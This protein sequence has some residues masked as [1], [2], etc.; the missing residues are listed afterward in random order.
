M[1]SFSAL[2]VGNEFTKVE[3]L[4]LS[5]FLYHGHDVKIYLYDM[6]TVVPNGVVKEDAAN[7]L[8]KESIFLTEGSYGPF[9]DIFR[10]EMIKK[11][12]ESWIDTDII[13]LKS[14][15]NFGEYVFGYEDE[16]SIVGSI[17]N[18]PKDSELLEKL[19]NHSTS[20]KREEI[21]WDQT[22]P[23]LITTIVK[24]LGLI[25]KA[26][27]IETFYPLNYWDWERLWKP[28]EKYNMLNMFRNS[29]SLQTWNQ[30][31]RRSGIDKNNLPIGSAIDFFYKKFVIGR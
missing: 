13:C 2:W 17:L 1:S 29:H 30:F 9:S 10:Y 12:G 4:C 24:E 23:K 3:E 31:V 18:I 28:E 25:D 6:D 22:G 19:Y 8:G 16:N 14:D 7:I 27:S 26:Q 5:S 15:W 20:L 11:T 21:E